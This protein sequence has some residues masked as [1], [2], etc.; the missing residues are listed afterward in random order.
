VEARPPDLPD[1]ERPLKFSGRFGVR[2][3]SLTGRRELIN[4]ADRSL[5]RVLL[6]I[7]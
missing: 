3:W 7:A 4:I 5:Y 6:E 1:D 2:C